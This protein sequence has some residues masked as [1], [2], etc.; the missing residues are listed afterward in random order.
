MSN[1]GITTS[2]STYRGEDGAANALVA[3]PTTAA[4][5]MTAAPISSRRMPAPRAAEPSPT[6]IAAVWGCHA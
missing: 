1:G 6:A 2:R 4:T 3:M 5:A